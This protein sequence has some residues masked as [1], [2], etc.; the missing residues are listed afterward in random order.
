MLPNFHGF[1]G[2]IANHLLE[3]AITFLSLLAAALFTYTSQQVNVGTNWILGPLT[4][5]L[6][7]NRAI[8]NTK[9]GA[10]TDGYE[11]VSEFTLIDLFLCD[12]DGRRALYRKTSSYVVAA[13]ELLTYQ[14]GVTAEGSVESI[15]TMRGAILETTIEHGFHISRI[16]LQDRLLKD[17]R[18]TNVY[19]ANL[20]DCFLKSE[21]HWTQEVAFQ[22]KHL[23]LQIHFPEG[24]PPTAIR[25]KSVEGTFDR[26]VATIAKMTDLFGKKSIVW[27][28]QNPRLNEILKLEWTW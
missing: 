6:P 8:D 18:F 4:R 9:T 17:S 13:D 14:E 20:H 27:D 24:R 19:V 23:T 10:P 22:T 7:W 15:D 3:S 12:K 26:P 16:N 21:E 5:A 2:F 25:C 1:M 11:L 28:V